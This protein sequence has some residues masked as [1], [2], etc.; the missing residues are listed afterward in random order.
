V[1]ADAKYQPKGEYLTDFTELD[2]TVP[3]HVKGI[4]TTNISHWDQ[5]W[6][7]A[8]EANGWGNHAD[9]GYA[10]EAWVNGK[11]YSTYTG[12]DAVKTS[13]NQTIAGVKTFT[14]TVNANK[15]VGDGSGLTGLPAAG[16]TQAQGDARYVMQSGNSTVSGTITATDFVATSDERV[17]D[18]I[19]TAPVGLIDSLKGRE[20]EWNESGEKGSGVVA[21]ELEQVLPHL[22]HTDDEGMKSVAYNGLVAYLIEEVK[23]LRAEVE[24]LK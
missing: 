1:E 5:A 11:N 6:D 12:A 17:K 18:N 19:T 9:A 23:A 16:L 22:V 10:T 2:P 15:F 13:G 7:E 14:E 4:T 21:Q 8:T 3:Q 24:A 20:W